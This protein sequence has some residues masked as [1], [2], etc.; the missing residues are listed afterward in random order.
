MAILPTITVD[1][2]DLKRVSSIYDAAGRKGPNVMADAINRS[3]SVATT[4][5]RRAVAKQMGVKYGGVLSASK[6]FRARPDNLTFDLV[7]RGNAI[8]LK[9]FSARQ[10][11]QGVRARPW[12]KARLFRGLFI[13]RKVGGHV[14]RRAP[15]G[16]R[17]VRRI[18]PTTGKP[19][20]S[21]LPIEVRYGP[22]LP[23][24]LV[25]DVPPKVWN[26][27][28]VDTYPE[29]V[30]RALRRFMAEAATGKERPRR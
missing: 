10:N 25:K 23:R 13:V 14:F 24:E 15:T 12:G 29:N 22:A 5:T 20:L 21:E 19:Y 28:I 9:E 1:A 30:E 18:S 3:G 8:P 26:D 17:R 16:T 27:S 6:T 4:A 11:K 7:G 2:N